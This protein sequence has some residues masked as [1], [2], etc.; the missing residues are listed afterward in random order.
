MG[1]RVCGLQEV[2]ARALSL[3][4][5]LVLVLAQQGGPQ[6]NVRLVGPHIILLGGPHSH[7]GPKIT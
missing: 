4:P 6:N 3:A 1:E 5:I 7:G 2:R